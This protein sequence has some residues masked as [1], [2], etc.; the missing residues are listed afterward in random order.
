DGALSRF[1]TSDLSQE[2]VIGAWNHGGEDDIDP[3]RDHWTF[4]DPSFDQQFTD[5]VAFFD[6]HLGGARVTSSPA[7]SIRYYTMNEG[8]WRTTDTWPPTNME[9]RRWFLGSDQSLADRPPLENG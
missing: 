8:R 9:P 1:M 7:K 5:L 4:S 3:F 6:N 2:L